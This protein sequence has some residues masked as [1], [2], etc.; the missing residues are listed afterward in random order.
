MGG[1]GGR[2]QVVERYEGINLL[3]EKWNNLSTDG[4]QPFSNLGLVPKKEK[5]LM[6]TTSNILCTYVPVYA[7]R[8]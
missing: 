6:K 2:E 7:F 4:I 3:G 5:F 1:R 8:H